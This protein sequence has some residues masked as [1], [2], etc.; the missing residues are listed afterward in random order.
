MWCGAKPTL[1]PSGPYPASPRAAAAPKRMS[2]SRSARSNVNAS[3]MRAQYR[4]A[5]AVAIGKRQAPAGALGPTEPDHPHA[6]GRVIRVRQRPGK[7]SSRL[8]DQRLRPRPLDDPGRPPFVVEGLPQFVE[9][10]G[11]EYFFVPSMTAL[12]MIGM[13][14]VDPT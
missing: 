12:R 10:R 8:A 2:V 4:R 9:T 5:E 7:C 3:G 1:L 14:V 6:T 13:G 11:G